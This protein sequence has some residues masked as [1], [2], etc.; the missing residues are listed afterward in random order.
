M[1]NH[2]ALAVVYCCRKMEW[3]SRYRNYFLQ[4]DFLPWSQYLRD[5]IKYIKWANGEENYNQMHRGPRHWKSVRTKVPRIHTWGNSMYK[6]TRK[7]IALRKWWQDPSYKASIENSDLNVVLTAEWAKNASIEEIQED[8][9]KRFVADWC[10][11]N[12]DLEII[13][14]NEAEVKNVGMKMC[15]VVV[16][17]I[18]WTL[19]HDYKDVLNAAAFEKVLEMKLNTSWRRIYTATMESSENSNR[20]AKRQNFWHQKLNN[21]E[22]EVAEQAKRG[23]I[24]K[25]LQIK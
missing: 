3:I 13:Y 15:L 17:T 25:S 8:E 6:A 23:R 21:L 12:L 19:L 5:D 2:I 4:E 20:L 14:F 1:G 24:S 16:E 10:D 9:N 7:Q 18:V 11:R 22:N